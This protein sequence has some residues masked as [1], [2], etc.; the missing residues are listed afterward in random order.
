MFGEDFKPMNVSSHPVSQPL[1]HLKRVFIMRGNIRLELHD[2]PHRP[3]RKE[4]NNHDNRREH[5]MQVSEHVIDERCLN[6]GDLVDDPILRVEQLV[7][8]F[9]HLQVVENVVL[10]L[11]R[12]CPV[13]G[14]HGV[15]LGVAD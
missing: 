7:V 10:V 12:D 4:H 6:E 8:G 14:D 3:R 15:E 5:E 1:R 9:H 2:R 13:E 11:G